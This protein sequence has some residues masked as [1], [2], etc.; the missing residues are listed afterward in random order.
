M[1]AAGVA[2]G[3]AAGFL[4]TAFLATGFLTAT[5]VVAVGLAG[6]AAGAVAASTGARLMLELI[7]AAI[8]AQVETRAKR[9]IVTP[10]RCCQ[11]SLTRRTATLQCFINPA[12]AARD[13]LRCP[14]PQAKP[15][16]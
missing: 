9:F 7:R 8:R 11:N 6:A 13:D 15:R 1:A 10:E 3:L 5:A 2:T 14:A 16:G 12:P 4:A